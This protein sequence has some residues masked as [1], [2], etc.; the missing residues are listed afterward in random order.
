MYNFQILD[1]NLHIKMDDKN[2]PMVYRWNSKDGVESRE[3]IPIMMK[4]GRMKRQNSASVIYGIF[5]VLMVDV[6][7]CTLDGRTDC[8]SKIDSVNKSA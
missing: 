1:V 8:F 2:R 6:T 5:V 7:K 4:N 3:P